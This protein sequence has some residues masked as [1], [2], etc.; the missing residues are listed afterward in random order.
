MARILLTL[1]GPSCVGKGP[2][3]AAL[4]R[5][6]PELPFAEPVVHTSRAPRPGE[7]DGVEFHF[8][9]AST[10]AGYNRER[11]FVYPMRDQIRAIDLV[12]TERLLAEHERVV[13]E[14]H[15]AQARAFR[16]HPRLRERCA[17]V[18]VLLQPLSVEEARALAPDGNVAAAVAE[19]MRVKQ[20][21]R[22]LRQGKL[23]TGA[24]LADI[25]TRAQA[26]WDEMQDTGDFDHVFVC[27]DAEGSDHWLFTPPLG[28]AGSLLR[29]VAALLR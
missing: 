23:L 26:A 9:D 10:I 1:S 7:R 2:L 24:E 21:H 19:V 13:V 18:A 20:I 4:R 11:Y 28:D 25:D 5:C 27:H 29:Q 22:A 12:E 14:I 16:E 3:L 17:A 15:P 6:H 8:R